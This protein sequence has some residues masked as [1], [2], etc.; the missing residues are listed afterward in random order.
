MA[1]GKGLK[2]ESRA[3]VVE[4]ARMRKRVVLELRLNQMWAEAKL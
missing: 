1:E 3:T 2:W 4:T